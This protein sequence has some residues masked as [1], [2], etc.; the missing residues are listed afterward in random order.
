[1]GPAGR[2]GLA[3]RRAR[4]SARRRR[5]PRVTLVLEVDGWPGHLGRPARRR[6]PHRGGRL[7]GGAQLLARGARRRSP[8]RA[9]RAA[10]SRTARCRRTSPTS[11]RSA[12]RSRCA[13]RS[14]GGSCGA[15]TTPGAGA[16]RRGR[17]GDRA[18]HGDGPERGAERQ[19]GPVPARCTRCARPRTAST[20]TSCNG[21]ARADDGL[22]VTW[23]H[24]RTAPD[25][26]PRPP[27]R[28]TARRPRRARVAARLRAAACFVCGPTGFVETVAATA[29]RSRARPVPHQDGEIRLSAPRR[30]TEGKST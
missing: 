19:Q 18:A 2:D 13:G 22:D 17:L 3:S 23:V 25:G 29:R 24:T 16:A 28:L 26:D 11:S 4:R 12:T 1:M 5:R 30:P 8:D 20:P 14:A 21:A 7:P 9:H 27:G 15:P 6:T 10:R